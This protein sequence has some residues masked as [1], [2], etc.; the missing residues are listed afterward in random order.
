[1]TGAGSVVVLVLLEWTVGLV[2]VSAWCQTWG[3]VRRGFFRINAWIDVALASLAVLSLRATEGAAAGAS[4]P[5]TYTTAALAVVYLAVQYSRSDVPGAVA[6]FA[7]GATGCGALVAAA[8]LV[9]GWPL[10]LGSLA[11]LSGAALTGGV[12]V[13]M[14]L[15]HWYLNQPGLKPWAL[16]RTTVLTLAAAGASALLGLV[17][18]GR[19]ST[20]STPGAALGLP[21]G[22]SFGFAFYLTWLV[23]VVFTAAVAAGARRCVAIRS[24]QSATGLY[25]VA[26]LTTGVA[27]FL[28]RYLMV[29]AT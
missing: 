4:M 14:L 9:A 23:L 11:L 29:N 27:E 10:W 8:G 26:L 17:A 7:A 13:G 2:A 15:G 28:V 12:T 1:M 24:I 18:Y 21:F 25:Y 6:G 20:A 5:L 3:V 22:S 16:A 19:L